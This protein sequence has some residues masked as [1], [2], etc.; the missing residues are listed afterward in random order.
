MEQEV[1]WLNRDVG[2][3]EESKRVA[4]VRGLVAEASGAGSVSGVGRA[5]A[6]VKCLLEL[7]YRIP[8][9]ERAAW[10]RSC[11]AAGLEAG[12]PNAE[13]L[14]ETARRL[15]EVPANTRDELRLHYSCDANDLIKAL[16]DPGRKFFAS[17]ER[18][19]ARRRALCGFVDEA[20]RYA[21]PESS[22]VA[23]LSLRD[24][25]RAGG[26]MS[27][28]ANFAL[29][30]L[31]ACSSAVPDEDAAK[32]WAVSWVRWTGGGCCVEAD[33]TWLTL[34]CRARKSLAAA[35]FE[36]A[37]TARVFAETYRRAGVPVGGARALES[38]WRAWPARY[39]WLAFVG[40]DAPQERCLRKLAKLSM[41]AVAFDPE[42]HLDKLSR[43][44][45][46]LR[47]YFHPSNAGPWT[48]R[49]GL[50]LA[51]LSREL[52]TCV[53]KERFREGDGVGPKTARDAVALLAPLAR[54]ALYS[55]HS[56]MVAASIA[57]LRDLC[58]VHPRLVAEVCVPALGAALD[59]EAAVWAHQAPA[60]LR[61]L[62][63]LARPLLVRRSLWTDNPDSDE[64]L[65]DPLRS[66]R[67]AFFDGCFPSASSAAAADD[68]CFAA[69]AAA[70][71]VVAKEGEA[72][73][74]TRPPLAGVLVEMMKAALAAVDAADDAKTR[75]ALLFFDS[76]LRWVPSLSRSTDEE[77][78]ELAEEWAPLF[79]ERLLATLEHRD[80]AHKVSKNGVVASARD[81]A[82]AELVRSV[83]TRLFW[84]LDGRAKTR[85]KEVVAAWIR[86]APPRAASAKDAASVVAA[87]VAGGGADDL[88]AELRE[89]AAVPAR[90]PSRFAFG[91]RLL[92]GATRASPPSRIAAPRAL[93][94]LEAALDRGLAHDDKTVSKA[95]RKLLRDALRGLLERRCVPEAATAWPSEEEE[96]GEFAAAAA[97][98]AV[99]GVF[100][101]IEPTED[102]VA[103]AARLVD[104]FALA[105]LRQASSSS[106]SRTTAHERVRALRQL[107]HGARG[108][109]SA[110]GDHHQD[111][112]DDDDD[113]GGDHHLSS[114]LHAGFVARGL[115]R[116]AAIALLLNA[117]E[118]EDAM[119]DPKVA[120]SALKAARVLLALRRSVHAYR[121]RASVAAIRARRRALGVDAATRELARLERRAEPRGRDD[122]IE[123]AMVHSWAR[124]L[125]AAHRD[126]RRI[127]KSR[128]TAALY[129][130][131]L[132]KVLE[133]ATHFYADVRNAALDVLDACWPLYSW[134]LKPR[135]GTAV[136]WLSPHKP[137]PVLLGAAGFLTSRAAVRKLTSDEKLSGA[138]CEKA[139]DLDSTISCLPVDDRDEV[140]DRLDAVVA[141]Y[142]ARHCRPPAD[143]P[144]LARRA[145]ARAVDPASHWRHR[146]VAAFVATHAA[147]AAVTSD[148]VPFVLENAAKSDDEPLPRLALAAL[149]R[150]VASYEEKATTNNNADEDLLLFRAFFSDNEEEDSRLN[151][152]VSALQRE[153]R[154]ERARDDDEAT[155]ASSPIVEALV[156]EARHSEPWAVFPKSMAPYSSRGFRSRHARFIKRLVRLSGA[157]PERLSRAADACIERALA[158]ERGAA[159]AA[160]AEVWAGALRV[161]LRR[162]LETA[163]FYPTIRKALRG[164]SPDHALCWADAVRY[165]G[166]GKA[167]DAL[168]ASDLLRLLTRDW[169]SLLSASSSSEGNWA[170]T[171]KALAV[172]PSVLYELSAPSSAALGLR[173]KPLLLDAVDH[174]YA[175]VRERI[176]QCL[177]ALAGGAVPFGAVLGVEDLA[178]LL[179]VVDRRRR[180]TAFAWARH[181]ARDGEFRV[182]AG[183]LACALDGLADPD[184]DHRALATAT[185]SAVMHAA[186]GPPDASSLRALAEALAEARR[187]PKW[188]AR[189]A[190]AAFL[191][192]FAA[193]HAFLLAPE[194]RAAATNALLRLASDDASEVRDAACASLA[195]II[196]ASPT[197]S[198]AETCLENATVLL[199]DNNNSKSNK[200]SGELRIGAVQALGASVLAFPYDVPPHVPRALVVLAQHSNAAAA[201]AASDSKRHHA[202]AVKDAVKATYAEFKRTHAD[203]WDFIKPF[204]TQDQHD[205]LADILT[206]GD[207]LV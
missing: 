111:G 206:T 131:M 12:L 157:S 13:K 52:A 70:V 83:T 156:R 60:A 93:A 135:L 148:L 74:T 4:E 109:C 29:G 100:E 62:A 154:R 68:D 45:K 149:M 38:T 66:Q 158:S 137:A 176:G 181:A 46:M 205:A 169:A 32:E 41:S 183:L 119:D 166:G 101:W 25:I 147:S 106:S 113:G 186:R 130:K 116:S 71:V 185:I 75:C 73:R 207:Y 168:A 161:Q 180:E 35:V 8:T 105:P 3:E 191:G 126:V 127:S 163:S 134:A 144:T 77:A 194:D 86:S 139:V 110:L 160:A 56:A 99:E 24:I 179:R 30:L 164:S 33:A 91:L 203:T 88:V 81:A 155:R 145:L 79:L 151:G 204:F 58:G 90:T 193:R 129:E 20:R 21:T 184:E 95:A 80:A 178:S 9:S 140:A 36:E 54:D 50:L 198:L 31:R 125:D 47:P 202:A 108:A 67:A 162:G 177:G 48:P 92:A 188:R 11:F 59:V 132:Q 104:R 51:E 19:S 14:L 63:A 39:R 171:A 57:A 133:L 97:A 55:R 23:W 175:A 102:A 98:A 107:T 165:A 122:Q 84:R 182:V 72:A 76:V 117:M 159:C 189:A 112:G 78:A 16:R 27:H 2:V 42:K 173:L 6:G 200:N 152:L 143:A 121:A 85:C 1:H 28:D 167:A 40:G 170:Q 10:I 89:E 197:A 124:S 87:C 153:H 196:S 34:L 17:A 44:A 128:S 65:R 199:P 43:L 64:F 94:Q 5:C 201:A 142:A 136:S 190:V 26:P 18:V 103:A 174:E 7:K 61:A 15:L 150:W 115:S 118:N 172:A 187:H 96:E 69:A 49:L 114:P 192:A 146:F 37:T 138:L 123:R 120:R 195:A 141:A 53:A 82:S 22:R